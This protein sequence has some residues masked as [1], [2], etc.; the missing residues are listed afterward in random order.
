MTRIVV[1][2]DLNLD[3]LA[4]GL[5]DVSQGGETRNLV[6]AV[7]GGSAATF[8][9]VA[10]IEGASVSFLGSVGTDLIG[11][12]LLQSLEV[13]G[14]HSVV[15]RVDRPSGVILSVRDGHER[16]MVCSR[17]ANDGL[18]A[19]WI[20]ESQFEHADHLHVS[21]YA[22]LAEQQREAAVRAIE[23][24]RARRIPIS[25]DPPPAD[26]IARAGLAR[27]QAALTQVSWLFP[28]ESEGQLL[29]REGT[30]EEIVD[31][32][33]GSFDA[34][35]LTLG[36]DGAVA[37]SGETRHRYHQDRAADADSTGAGDAYAGAF[38]VA[39]HKTQD[40]A[41]ANRHACD[42]AREHL[43]RSRWS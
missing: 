22:L 2:G 30:P 9:R 43:Q 6:L 42:V 25:V 32:L 24:A 41:F 21:G 10:A 38:V 40:L 33:A 20:R 13:A 5:R 31:A 36:S 15:R 11:D 3:V 8:A 16:T 29:T 19:D 28:N 18:T 7:P 23:F 26:F 1:L 14:V 12:L 39:L 35:A 4:A 27:F 34:G 17:G 37:W